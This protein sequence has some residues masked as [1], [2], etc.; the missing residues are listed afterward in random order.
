MKHLALILLCL[1]FI[2]TSCGTTGKTSKA[3][4]E[5]QREVSIA[6]NLE[7]R[8]NTE[9]NFVNL[10]YYRLQVL[11]KLEDFQEVD[12]TL[13]EPDE[14]PEIIL[15]VNID[16]FV[17]WPRDEQ[18]SR[19]V[20]SRVVQTGTD[21]SGKPVYQTVSASIDIVR[22]QR[23]SNARV[24]VDLIVKGTPGKSYKQ[25]FAPRYNYSVTFVDN[26]QGD[27]RAVDSSIYFSRNPGVEPE[28]LDF[29]LSL[30][31][32]M[33]DRVSSQLRSYYRN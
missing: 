13:V 23:R 28:T 3:K 19:R 11:R 7:T 17:L 25:S 5:P 14:N 16:N 15:N 31:D 2:A 9:L 18:K 6:I 33:L 32:E 4:R 26:I 29:L 21:A 22:V 20:V 8:K 24:L 1:V 30:S 27:P 12:L 10:D